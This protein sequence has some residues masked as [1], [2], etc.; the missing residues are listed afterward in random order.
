MFFENCS[1]YDRAR[2]TLLVPIA[3]AANA[4]RRLAVA[5]LINRETGKLIEISLL[6]AGLIPE[7]KLGFRDGE[8]FLLTKSNFHAY[9]AKVGSRTIKQKYPQVKISAQGRYASFATEQGRRIKVN[10]ASLAACLGE[11]YTPAHTEMDAKGKMVLDI[12]SY[13]GETAL[14]YIIQGGALHVH[15][16]EPVRSLYDIIVDNIRINSLKPKITAYNLMVT[17]RE[18]PRFRNTFTINGDGNVRSITLDQLVRKLRLHDAALKLDV[19]GGEYDI[20]TNASREALRRFRA[21]HIEYHYGYR[22]LV[23]RLESEG[24]KVR[25]T[26]PWLSIIG[27][28]GGAKYMGEIFATRV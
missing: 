3:L 16:F 24:F 2:L 21:M 18:L 9:L 8:Q 22:D 27:M 14:Y 4:Q 28:L 12:G 26:G 7:V 15:T 1:I 25:R 17:G 23:E 20:I 19:E 13:M 6:Y 5:Q 11:L 10:S